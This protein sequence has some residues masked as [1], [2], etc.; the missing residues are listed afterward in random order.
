MGDLVAFPLTYPDEDFRSIVFHSHLRSPLFFSKTRY[1]LLGEFGMK[2]TVLFPLNLSRIE[3]EFELTPAFA[4]RIIEHHT[5]YPFLRPFTSSEN[6]SK[7]WEVMYSSNYDIKSRSLL[8][9]VTRLLIHSTPKYCPHCIN[10]DFDKYGIVYLHRIHQ[11]SFLHH[12]LEHNSQLIDVC[13]VCEIPL[14]NEDCS[15]MLIEPTCPNG[16]GIHVN[17]KYSPQVLNENKQLINDI[18]NLM[19]QKDANLDTTFIKI[20][21]SAGAKGYIRFQGGRL[22]K[23]KLLLDFSNFYGIEYLK[24]IGLDV[25]QLISSRQMVKL[26]EKNYLKDNFILYLLIM[27]FFG[28]EV[29]EWFSKDEEYSI[30]IPFGNGPWLCVNKICPQYNRRVIFKLLRK[31]QRWVTGQFTCPYCGIIYTRRGLPHIEDERTYNIDTMGHLFIEQAINYYENGMTIDEIATK[32]ASNRVTIRKYLL[33]HRGLKRVRDYPGGIEPA[34]VIEMGYRQAA[35]ANWN[36]R[37]DF[38]EVKEMLGPNASRH[39]FRKCIPSQYEWLLKNDREWIEEHL[40]SRKAIPQPINTKKLDDELF[41]IMEVAIETVKKNPPAGQ[42]SNITFFKGLP[43]KLKARYYEFQNDLPRTTKLLEANVESI[44]QYA[45]RIL[46]YALDKIRNSDS[47]YRNL[48][49]KRL[50]RISTAYKK[51]SLQV[52]EWAIKEANKYF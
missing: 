28:G 9:R 35:A 37:D 13:P 19:K 7:F 6:Q 4:Q 50:Q 48:S 36:Y 14:T 49:I 39:N 41:H 42:I 22:Y 33:P 43:R 12:C 47:K 24:L 38:L 51:C 40:P 2:K 46:P 10:N 8:L 5:F 27:R 44:D 25:N 52:L 21:C 32:V 45:I 16:H 18:D 31:A 1:K 15:Q 30:P 26:F 34:N 17:E 11:C 20:I 3:N 23:K 29:G